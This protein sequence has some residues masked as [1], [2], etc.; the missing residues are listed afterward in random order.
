MNPKRKLEIDQI[1]EG[2]ADEFEE[3]DNFGMVYMSNDAIK[4][5][6]T[7]F[8]QASRTDFKVMIMA[9]MGSSDEMAHDVI[10]ATG[11]FIRNKEQKV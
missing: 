8:S 5:E 11:A 7:L 6:A 4:L 3:D 9:L 2:F 1:I 10:L